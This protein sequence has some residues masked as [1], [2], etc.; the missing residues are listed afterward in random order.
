MGTKQVGRAG[1]LSYVEVQ[2]GD[3]GIDSSCRGASDACDPC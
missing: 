2:L 3:S 1:V